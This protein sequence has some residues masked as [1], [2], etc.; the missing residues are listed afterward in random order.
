MTPSNTI[1]MPHALMFRA[2]PARAIICGSSSTAVASDYLGAVSAD[3]AYQWMIGVG[4]GGADSSVGAYTR[5][6][7]SST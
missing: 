4:K 2:L 1:F 6:L 5:P 7:F 3:C